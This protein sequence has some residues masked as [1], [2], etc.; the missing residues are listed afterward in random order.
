MGSPE[1]LSVVY[2]DAQLLVLD[3][4]AGL[5]TQATRR[6]E[7]GADNL[8]DRA[9]ARY[10]Y[11]GL[12]H[13]LDVAVSGLVLLTLDPGVNEPIARAFREHRISRRY[14][15][16]VIGTVEEDTV[17]ERPIQGKS[18]STEVRLEGYSQDG[19]LT[20][21][22]LSPLTGRTHQLRIHAAL[23]GHPLAGD[24]QYADP[25]AWIWPRLALHATELSLEHP[26]SRAPLLL[27]SPLP[28][29]LEE[30]WE[31]ARARPA[32]RGL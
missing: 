6:S 19:A 7:R 32:G 4:P 9:R 22:R 10:P 31:R 20:A 8:Y 30:L 12:H 27:H 2:E 29:D 15:A 26:V 13:R 24:R 1:S 16:V 17:W 5:P 11:V 18:A 23:A 14:L 25:S 21:L 28:P 3:K